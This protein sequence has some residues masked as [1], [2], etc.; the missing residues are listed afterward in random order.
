MRILKE[1][2]LFATGEI[3]DGYFGDK[4]EV[5][6]NYHHPTGKTVIEHDSGCYTYQ[7][8]PAIDIQEAWWLLKN[9][10]LSNADCLVYGVL[11]LPVNTKVKS[12]RNRKQR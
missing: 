4:K 2:T 12:G 5:F 9:H 1:C 6:F 10:P 11:R 7:T 3:P 8:P